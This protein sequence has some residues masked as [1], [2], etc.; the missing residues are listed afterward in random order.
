MDSDQIETQLSVCADELEKLTDWEKSF[1][2]SISDQFD[3]TAHL[4]TRQQ[5]ILKQIYD[6]VV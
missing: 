3:R 6:K 1:I 2:E 5:E 4:S